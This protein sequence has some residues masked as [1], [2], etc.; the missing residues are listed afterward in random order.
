M[1]GN[2]PGT[3]IGTWTVV[4]GM[5]SGTFTNNNQYDTPVTSLGKGTNTLRWT[6]DNNGCIDSDDVE[7]T[8]DLPTAPDAG[9]DQDLCDDNIP[10]LAANVPAVGTGAWT[11]VAGSASFTDDTSPT[12]DATGLSEGT[13]TLRWTITNNTC[14]LTDDIIV[15]M[16]EVFRNLRIKIAQT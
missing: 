14:I 6:I 1:N 8:N 12:T 5:G 4:A 9:A 3:G 7:I 13:N 15:K 11:V 16:N 10:A 2:D